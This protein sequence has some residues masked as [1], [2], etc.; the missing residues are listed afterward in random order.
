MAFF[1]ELKRR[2]VGKVAIAYG[3]IAWLVTEASSVVLPAL[4]LPEWTVTFVVVFLLVGFPIAMVLAWVF[5]VGPQGIER[6][7]PV[8]GEPASARVKLRLAYSAVVLLLMA[9]LGYLLYERG[10]GRAHAGEPHNSIA[11]L[12][13]TNLSGDPARDFFSDGMSEELLNLLAR[14]PGLQVASRTSSFAYKGRN[15][16]IREVGRELGVETVLEG[17]VRQAGAQVR[18]TAQLIDAE[19]GFHLWSETYERR[20]EDIFQV[21]DEIA[22]AIVAKLRIELAPQEQALAV[23]DKAPTQNMQAYEFYL[24]GREAWKKRGEDNLRRAIDLYQRALGLDPGF[25]RAYA[26]LASAY[27]VLPGYTPDEGDEAQLMPLAETAARRALS[28]DPK[29]GEAHAVLAQMNAQRGDLLDAES[30]FFF[31]I[32]LEPNEATPHHWYSLLLSGVGRVDQAL[33]QARRAQ[34]LDPSSAV[35]ALNLANM[36]LMKGENDAALGYAKRAQQL[37]LAKGIHG[38]EAEIAIRRGQ[39]DAARRLIVQQEELPDAIRPQAVRFVDA[40]ADPAIRPQVVAEMRSLDPKVVPQ[41][42][43]IH[44]YIQLGQVD[45]AYQILFA[46]LDRDPKAWLKKW[47][48]SMAWR[49]EGAAFRDDKRFGQLAER[50][51]L[52]D[53]WKQYGYP[54]G[55]RASDGGSLV[56]S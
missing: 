24:Q 47:D 10:F 3:T 28:I 43:L 16:D 35:I 50:M 22:A 30:G 39:W 51:G 54:D 25:A 12:P 26:A 4:R 1:A 13:F 20:M 11:V 18:I 46:E 8:A 38:V 7:E 34:E 15:V 52:V 9:A 32:S 40:L 48:L 5:D 21:Q 2:R 23:R 36:H 44:P 29:I 19:T 6:T 33:E 31:A 45:L 56:C 53:Y 49:P 37:G 42:E 14:V 55:C 27:V 41:V 17:S